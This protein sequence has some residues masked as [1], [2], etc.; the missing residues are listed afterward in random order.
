MALLRRQFFKHG[1]A[2]AVVIAIGG[3]T[4]Y[5]GIGRSLPG[6][7]DIPSSVWPDLDGEFS[8]WEQRFE[9]VCAAVE[10]MGFERCEHKNNFSLPFRGER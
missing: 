6:R 1:H 8:D 4:N 9:R 10:A 2:S 7:Q 3:P 5:V